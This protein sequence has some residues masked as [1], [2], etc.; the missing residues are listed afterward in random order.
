ML[1]RHSLIPIAV[2]VVLALSACGGGATD[3]TEPEQPSLAACPSAQQADA[4]VELWAS[5]ELKE[6]EDEVQK[7]VAE[8][9]ASAP[10]EGADELSAFEETIGPAIGYADNPA[11][12]ADAVADE[13]YPD[14]NASEAFHAWLAAIGR[15]DVNV[16]TARKEAREAS[17][18]AEASSDKDA[19]VA[20]REKVGF[21]IGE[22]PLDDDLCDLRDFNDDGDPTN[23][24]ILLETQFSDEPGFSGVY[25][26]DAMRKKVTDYLKEWMPP[27][28]KKVELYYYGDKKGDMK[29]ADVEPYATIDLE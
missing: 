4:L 3:N 23:G 25:F 12:Y 15:D 8:D 24:V 10:C 22:C 5:E 26:D 28:I 17:E 13:G 11:D 2:G 18:S 16:N 21:P 14:T 1:S 20:G 7:L 29:A 9:E 19:V 27:Q 6:L